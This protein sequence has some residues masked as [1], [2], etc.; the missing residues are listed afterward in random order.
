MLT[1]MVNDLLDMSLVDAGH[2]QLERHWLD[3]EAMVREVVERLSYLMRGRARIHVSGPPVSVW[4]DRMR[5][6]QVLG[7]LLSNAVKYGE[8]D[9]EIAVRLTR[10]EADIELAVSNQG[11]GISPEE[12]PHLF[13]RFV[14][15]RTA[16]RSGVEGLGLGLYIAKGLVEAHGGRIW[17]ESV[18][19]KTTTFHIVL[20]HRVSVQKVA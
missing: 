4:I 3:P 12:M 1:R 20:P 11:R 9:T 19:G 13:D 10:R 2:L 17:A 6:E 14:R 8:P 15:S 5:I 18:P 7:N 16:R